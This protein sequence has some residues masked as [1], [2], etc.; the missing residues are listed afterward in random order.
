MSKEGARRL[1]KAESGLWGKR[2]D[3][4]ISGAFILV[5]N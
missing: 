3:K 2:G 1:I 4:N 5:V